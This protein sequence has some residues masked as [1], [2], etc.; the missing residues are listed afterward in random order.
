[1]NA[2]TLFKPT[3]EDRCAAFDAQHPE[4]YRLFRE[5]ALEWARGTKKRIGAKAVAEVMRWK[6][7]V[8][9]ERYG[10]VK[11]NNTY[12]AVWARRLLKEHPELKGR[13]E[14]RE[15]KK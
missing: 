2:W 15:R 4:S 9:P 6:S 14:L 5:I 1:M 11:V 13:I 10:S 7:D 12:V 3:I 8:N